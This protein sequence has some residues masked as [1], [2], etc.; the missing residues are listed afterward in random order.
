MPALTFHKITNEP[1]DWFYCEVADVDGK[2]AYW[3]KKHGERWYASFKPAGWKKFGNS[4]QLGDRFGKGRIKSYDT[5][6]EAK[7]VAQAHYEKFGAFAG[8]NSKLPR[9]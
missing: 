8:A 2:Q 5:I 6:E 3:V 4:C 7:A 1:Y 9:S